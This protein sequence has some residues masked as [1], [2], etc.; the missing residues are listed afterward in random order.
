ME[1]INIYIILSLLGLAGSMYWWINRIESPEHRIIGVIMI[2]I[3]GYAL[4][5]FHEKKI[6][7]WGNR[8]A[9]DGPDKGPSFP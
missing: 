8:A 7:L 5:R 3:F 6:N 4:G 2:S 1:K 9:K